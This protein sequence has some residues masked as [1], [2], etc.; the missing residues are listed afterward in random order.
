MTMYINS[1]LKGRIP[2][3]KHKT[4]EWH[5]WDFLFTGFRMRSGLVVECWTRDRGVVGSG[6]T[7]VTALCP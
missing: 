6:L 7:G 1:Q 4:D 2:E 3:I 5:V